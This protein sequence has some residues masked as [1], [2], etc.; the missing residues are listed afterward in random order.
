MA[1][2]KKWIEL[3]RLGLFLLLASLTF[4]AAPARAGNIDVDNARLFPL[5]EGGY[6]LAADFKID[7]NPRLEEAVTKG[8]TLY[9][10]LD[11]ELE[12]PR[13]FWVDER[14]VNR[15][16]T[17]RLSYHALTRQYRLSAG[18]LH[19]SFPSLEEAIQVL[20]RVR[21]WQV[22]DTP[23]KPGDTY[24]AALRMRLDISLLPKP[25][26]VSALASRDWNLNSD[27]VQ[28]Q[29]IVPQPEAVDTSAAPQAAPIIQPPPTQDAR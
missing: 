15:S 10:T 13:W 18:T 5:E 28:W 24:Q 12:R 25:F 8:V 23:L 4:L 20:S 19:L 11:F 22:I 3:L 1:S 17:W 14:V 9:F 2:C 26:Q 27:W 6:A 21:R 7:F 29:F 16:Q